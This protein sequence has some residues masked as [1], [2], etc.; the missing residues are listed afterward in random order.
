M[1]KNVIGCTPTQT[2]NSKL[3]KH[4]L[5]CM[6][7][8]YWSTHAGG[9]SQ[10]CCVL[11]FVPN[12]P[13]KSLLEL[14]LFPS[15]KMC[16]ESF[17]TFEISPELYS[18]N[19]CLPHYWKDRFSSA[20]QTRARLQTHLIEPRTKSLHLKTAGPKTGGPAPPPSALI[21]SLTPFTHVR[22]MF[23]KVTVSNVLHTKVFLSFGST[24]KHKIAKQRNQNGDVLLPE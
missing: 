23:T 4:N 12:Q 6:Q 13:I 22:H 16:S 3:E 17:T 24:P 21:P 19:T 18:P 9:D 11:S 2:Q 8:V 20:L 10:R 7:S 15:R 14:F 1:G 5:N